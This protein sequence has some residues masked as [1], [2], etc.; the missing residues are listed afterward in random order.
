MPGLRTRSCDYARDKNGLIDQ[1]LAYRL[2]TGVAVYP[3]IWRVRLLLTSRVWDPEQDICIWEA[4][5]GQMAGLALLWRRWATSP[6]LV[7]ERF[8]HPSSASSELAAD[9]LGWGS[10]RAEAIVA[11]QGFPLSAY[12]QD[13]APP[14]SI[15]SGYESCGFTPVIIDPNQ[16]NVYYGR[17]LPAP[18]PAP[19]LPAGYSI[20]PVQAAEE[21][22][23]FQS[24][25]S[26]AVVN[27]DHQRE[28]FDSEE[29]CHLVAVDEEG[30]LAAYCESSICRREWQASG[31]RIGWI[32]YI[33]T[34]PEQQGRGLGQAVMWAGLERLRQMGAETALLVT[35]SSNTPANRLYAKTGFERM[36]N[37]EPPRYEKR[38]G[39][40]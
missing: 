7:L 10:R 27:P 37:L 15:D 22:T 8:V 20:R 24:L 39:E 19:Q 21:M 31:Q 26:F 3:T 17:P 12:A 25:Y 36:P 30:S 11:G 18:L 9:M 35:L 32:D 29:Y 14:L 40:A 2:L 34:R 28:L 6:Y 16:D 1:L 13:F 38:F 5:S 33:E 23:A 4:P